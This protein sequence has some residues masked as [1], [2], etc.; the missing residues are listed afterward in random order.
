MGESHTIENLTLIFLIICLYSYILV[1]TS[2]FLFA[3]KLSINECKSTHPNKRINNRKKI[4]ETVIDTKGVGFKIP[5]RPNMGDKGANNIN[6]TY[7]IL[8][9][10]PNLI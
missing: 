1:Y 9:F 3:S 5:I 10:S 7:T 6:I 4:I 8:P 2:F